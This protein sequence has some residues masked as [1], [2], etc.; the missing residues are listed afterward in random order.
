VRRI[1]VHHG[2]DL[3]IRSDAPAR[4][5][6]GG[7][8]ALVTSVVG[9]LAELSGRD[10]SRHE[11]AE[12]SYEIERNDLG[13]PGGMRDQYAA[14][15]ASSAA[16]AAADISFSIVSPA[17]ARRRRRARA[18]WRSILAVDFRQSGLEVRRERMSSQPTK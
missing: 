15:V 18:S 4:S 7:S 17:S 13:I 5:G 16:R 14:L 8:S 12:V 10:L 6:L 9:A 1:G 11:L 2:I 3:D